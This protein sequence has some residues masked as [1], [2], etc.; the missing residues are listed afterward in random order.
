M[1]KFFIIIPVFNEREVIE[2]LIKSL[3]KNGYSSTVIFVDDGSEDGTYEMIKDSGFAVVR[4]ERN[5]GKGFSQRRGFQEALKRDAE[6]LITMDGDLQHDPSYIKD[7]LAKVMEGNDIVIGSRWNELGKMPRDRY[8]SNRLTTLAV[9]L[10]AKKKIED[11]QSGFRAYKREVVES[12]SFDSDKF[13]AESELLMKALVSG[14]KLGY[15][16]I[17]ALYHERLKSKIRR[18]EDTLRFLK[19]FFKLVW[20]RS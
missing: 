7:F 10:F 4:N 15:V 20:K 19:M 12:I 14:K 1:L 16:S 2:D 13:E 9:S 18:L 17:P 5:Y 8:L 6:I 11:S 3:N